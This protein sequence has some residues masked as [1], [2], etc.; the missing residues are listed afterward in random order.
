MRH[1]PQIQRAAGNIQRTEVDAE[2]DQ[3]QSDKQ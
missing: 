1:L 2:E 3:F